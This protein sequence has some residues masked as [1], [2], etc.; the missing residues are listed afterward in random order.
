VRGEWS[1]ALRSGAFGGFGGGAFA[2]LFEVPSLTV[3]TAA[4]IVSFT[5]AAASLIRRRSSRRC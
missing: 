2:R 1:G 3:F 5:H 4:A